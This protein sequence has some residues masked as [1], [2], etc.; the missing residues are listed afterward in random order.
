M[1]TWQVHAG[2]MADH[3]I[4]TWLGDRPAVAER[5]G[6]RWYAW[7]LDPEPALAAV[8]TAVGDTEDGALANLIQAVRRARPADPV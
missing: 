2:R 7:L 4:P 5:E 8:R 3:A 1:F 6:T